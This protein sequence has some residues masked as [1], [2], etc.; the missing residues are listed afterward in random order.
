MET[1]DGRGPR[2]TSAEQ[3]NIPFPPAVGCFISLIT[4]ALAVMVFFFVLTLAKQGEVSFKRGE[5]G[6]IRIWL[7][8]QGE[9]RGL[10]LSSTRIVHGSERAGE[11]C[12]ETKVQFL[13]WK[14]GEG[15]QNTN[16]CECYR[17]QG[18]SWTSTGECS[19]EIQSAVK[20]DPRASTSR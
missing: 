8:R 13:L 17:L 1:V 4:G 7:I 12:V 20:K 19:P 18:E 15:I 10:G 9:N 16:Y 5:L 3:A 14:S 11:A 6:E 2:R